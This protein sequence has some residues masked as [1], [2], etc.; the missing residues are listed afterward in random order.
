MRCNRG[1]AAFVALLALNACAASN[2]GRSAAQR[3]PATTALGI[4]IY[5]GAQAD[6]GGAFTM[7]IGNR[8][9]QVA[10]FQTVDSFAAVQAFYR[11]RLPPG[12]QTISASTADGFAATFD[13]ASRG[14]RVTVEVASS[15]PRETDILVK[16]VRPSV[17]AGS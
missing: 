1:A 10:A 7:R 14:E 17:R 4:P 8:M 11:R 5:P 3:P 2:T 9:V 16:R 6:S 15:K 13:F 12:S